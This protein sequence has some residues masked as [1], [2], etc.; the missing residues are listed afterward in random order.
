MPKRAE[1]IVRELC[2]KIGITIDGPNPWD[3]KVSDPRFY[4]R[5]LGEGSLGL[6]ESY[7]DGWWEVGDLLEMNAIIAAAGGREALQKLLADAAPLAACALLQL[8]D[9]RQRRDPGQGP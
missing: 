2:T 6:G 3:P 5:V 8:A 7:M 1:T 9:H 4:D